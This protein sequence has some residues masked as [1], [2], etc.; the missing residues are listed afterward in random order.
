MLKL[1]GQFCCDVISCKTQ[2]E[3]LFDS[4]RSGSIFS[5]INSFCL[6]SDGRFCLR[7]KLNKSFLRCHLLRSVCSKFVYQ[8]SIETWEMSSVSYTAAN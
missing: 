5:Q 7:R 2:R 4:N 8:D 1:I 6:K 3:S